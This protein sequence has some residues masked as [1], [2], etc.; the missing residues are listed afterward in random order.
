MRKNTAEFNDLRMPTPTSPIQPLPLVEYTGRFAGD[1]D[2]PYHS[3]TGNELVLVVEGA[4]R[5]HVGSDCL[6]GKPG[7]LFVLPAG[8]PQYQ[9]TLCYTRTSYIVF[10][11]LRTDFERMSRTVELTDDREPACRWMEDLCDLYHGP[12][13]APEVLTSALLLAILERV[14]QLEQQSQSETYTHPAIRHTLQL[15]HDQLNA[16]FTVASL[17]NHACV[18]ASH[19]TALFIDHFDCGPLHYLQSLRL[20]YAC[21]LL[22]DPNQSIAQVAHACGYEDANYFIRLFRKR[23]GTTPGK[24]R[25]REHWISAT[26]PVTLQV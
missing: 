4:C 25:T 8:V 2:C 7:T 13:A 15:F 5:M 22:R 11:T 21:K 19:L 24:W 10:H 18:S 1:M 3:H 12:A 17:A 14:N 9:E 16:P 20:Q 23:F 6:E 26:V